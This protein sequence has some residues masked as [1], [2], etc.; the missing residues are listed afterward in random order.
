[1]PSSPDAQAAA[2]RF[3]H[4]DQTLHAMP[5]TAPLDS[6]PQG[7]P[8]PRWGLLSTG[9]LAL[10][11]AACSGSGAAPQAG[12]AG[13]AAPAPE[14]G[15]LQ[16]QPTATALELEL[17]GRLEAARVAQVRARS[18]G[19]VQQRLFTEGSQVRAGQVLFR[20]ESASADAALAS[21]RAQQ[22]RAEAQLSQARSVLARYRPLAA[23][24]AISQQELV[25]A[26]VA[27][28]LAQAELELA[29]A[30]VQTAR[31]QR[32]HSDV[33]APIAGRVG[34]ALVSEGALVG[35]ADATPM[36][37]I[38]QTDTLY[39]NFTR[40][41]NEVLQM[42]QAL[43]A[44]QLQ[45]AAG[46]AAVA[47]ALLLPDS[48]LYPHP[49]RLLFTDLNVDP[50]TGQVTLRASIPNP[51]GLLLPGLYV[52]VRLAQA[53]ASAAVRLPTQAIQRGPRGDHVLLV[54]AAGLVSERPVTLGPPQGGQ[55]LVLAGLNAGE[56][57]VVDGFQRIG[58][59]ATVRPVPWQA[60]ADA[61]PNR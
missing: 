32:S 17:P 38:Q 41:A 9:L 58:V 37:L 53:Q 19:I 31:I 54:D 35:Q 15:V 10:V 13:A 26:E 61:A 40:S 36:A 25:Q 7:R 46:G 49:G 11:L 34:R 52:R 4:H 3:A 27:L 48:S 30:A 22:S 1:M 45:R 29:Q 24:Q 8:T 12:A 59:G 21:A 60:R 28:Q 42:Q 6:A 33:T 44:G 14:V 47:V 55:V 5:A 23:E 39:L 56:Q 50:G 16:V 2:C 18:S 57:V 20:I 51:D 43:R